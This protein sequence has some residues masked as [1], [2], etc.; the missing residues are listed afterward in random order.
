V[1]Q[2]LQDKAGR[3]EPLEPEDKRREL[4]LR[5]QVASQETIRTFLRVQAD[6]SELMNAVNR[7]LEEA[8]GAPRK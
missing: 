7:T 5:Q 8:I 1:A 4:D 3:G 6:F 2:G